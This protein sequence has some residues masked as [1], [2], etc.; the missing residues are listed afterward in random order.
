MRRL[1]LLILGVTSLMFTFGTSFADPKRG[2][3]LV[4]IYGQ[5]PPHFNSAIKSGATLYAGASNIFVGLVEINKNFEAEPYLAKSWEISDD[6][7]T[8]TFHLEEGTVFHDGKP[9]TS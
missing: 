1:W 3:D 9:V 6:G 4:H 7:L 2:G 8:Y 5:F